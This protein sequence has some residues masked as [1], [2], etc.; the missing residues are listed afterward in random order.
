MLASVA[1][2]RITGLSQHLNTETIRSAMAGTGAWAPVIYM[3]T[4]TLAPALML[5][6]LPISLAGGILFGPF[7]GVVYTI[8]SA[9]AGAC[10]AFLVS[11]YVAREW[12]AN[13]LR[14]PRW[15]RLDRQVEENGWK[16]VAFTRLIPLFPFNLLNYAFGL[17]RIRFAHYAWATFVFMLPATIAFITFSSSLLDLLNGKISADFTAGLLL[18]AVVSA[19]PALHRGYAARPETPQEIPGRTVRRKAA[20]LAFLALLAALAGLWLRFNFWRIDSYWYTFEF[21][22]DFLTNHL[23]AGDTPLVGEY[24]QGAGAFSALFLAWLGNLLQA[25]RFPFTP[26][27]LGG[28]AAAA[29]GPF[30]GTVLAWAA[31]SLA[32]LTLWGLAAFFLGDVIP[33]VRSRRGDRV[34]RP[35]ADWWELP[36]LALAAFPWAPLALVPVAGGFLGVSFVRLAVWLGSGL[37]LRLA[38]TSL[39]I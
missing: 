39:V 37:L 25:F 2:L 22:L 24:L 31:S 18:M 14:G 19:I 9:T 27:V 34:L 13:R 26:S 3:L 38:F 7:W 36:A 8:T 6:G 29:F 16:I 32:A 5:P 33:L 35:P 1:A 23:S 10:L 15:R 4:Y 21:H 17:T 12:V 20:R 30:A 28:A 11:R